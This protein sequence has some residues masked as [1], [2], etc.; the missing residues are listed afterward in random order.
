MI[1]NKISAGNMIPALSDM[2][3]EKPQNQHDLK[4]H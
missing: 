1:D 4:K 2:R 3:K